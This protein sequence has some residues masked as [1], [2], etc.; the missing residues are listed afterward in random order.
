MTQSYFPK[1]LAFKEWR[2]GRWYLLLSLFMFSLDP[3]LSLSMMSMS[4]SAGMVQL[5]VLKITVPGMGLAT[6][7]FS[8]GLAWLLLAELFN[9]G[10]LQLAAE[11]VSAKAIVL[12]KFAWGLCILFVGQFF[13]ALWLAAGLGLHQALQPLTPFLNWWLS[14]LVLEWVVYSVTFSMILL[15]RPLIVALF[16]TAAV[17]FAPEAISNW[18]L[19][20]F[21]VRVPGEQ[22]SVIQAPLWGRH[23]ANVIRDISPYA[24][25]GFRSLYAGPAASVFHLEILEPLV[26]MLLAVG[27]IWWVVRRRFSV[28]EGS[29][30]ERRR[31]LRR[32]TSE[33]TIRAIS[34]LCGAVLVE[35]FVLR[36]T[37]SNVPTK[38]LVILFL[39]LCCDALARS[40]IGSRRATRR[41]KALRHTIN[42]A[43]ARNRG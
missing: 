3:F 23:L 9:N 34:T 35:H 33:G 32:L 28:A 11:P 18:F 39:W 36:T 43:R 29:N 14:S 30:T 42:V 40:V 20:V 2:T 4:E 41:R 8:I 31:F 1:A 38:V 26:L 37:L 24:S 22:L 7:G 6:I 16:F 10:G 19:D 12:T 15:V 13:T 21:S 5:N 25:T 27:G 17:T